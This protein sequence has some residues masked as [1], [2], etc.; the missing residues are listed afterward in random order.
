MDA[1]AVYG[2]GMKGKVMDYG[3]KTH[4]MDSLQHTPLNHVKQITLY[5]LEKNR[6]VEQIHGPEIL[7]ELVQYDKHQQY[8]IKEFMSPNVAQRA[9]G[10]TKK[11]Y[12]LRELAGFQS[13]LPIVK[14]H[15]VVGMPYHH[16]FLFGFEIEMNHSGY[17]YDGSTTRCFVINRK[18]KEVMKESLVNAFR[19]TQFVQFVED[20]LNTLVEI[21]RHGLAHGDIKLDNIMKCGSKYELIDWENCR[22]LEYAFLEQHRYLGLSPFYFKVLYGS[23]WYPAFKIALLKYYQETGGYDTFTSSQY[24]DQMIEYYQPLFKTP[25]HETFK[26]VKNSLDLCAFGMILYGIMQRNPFISKKHHFFIMNLYKMKSAA[27]ALKRF[28]SKKTRKKNVF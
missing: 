26:K 17:I 10:Y 16:T 11:E 23:G 22:K 14:K 13:I 3:T 27:E 15:K 21:Q 25:I 5:V 20:I 24:A 7:K 18:C 9:L 19:E 8:V 12:M 28:K 2:V 6:I 4:D 1:G